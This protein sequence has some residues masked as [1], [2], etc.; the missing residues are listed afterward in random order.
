MSYRSIISLMP[1]TSVDA[2]A[3]AFLTAAAITDPTISSSIDKLVV[4]MKS[5]GV[6]T[7][8]KAIYPMVGGTASTHKFNLKD[9][10]D[11]DAAFRLSF[12]GGWTHSANGALPNGTNGYAN[13]FLTASSQ[14][15]INSA[16]LSFY[17]RTQLATGAISIGSTYGGL[18][19]NQANLSLSDGVNGFFRINSTATSGI[20]NTSSLGLHI[21]NRISSSETRNSI[22]GVL[23]TQ[24]STS[25]SLNTNNILLAASILDGHTLTGYDSKQCAFSSIGMGL[26]DTEAANFY[27]AVQTF[28]TSLGRSIGTQT[29]SDADAQAFV[30]NAA[31]VDQVEANAVNKLVIDMKAA[32]VWSKMKAIYPFVGG[33]ASSHKFNLKDPRDLD[34]AF[35]LQFFGGVT[36]SSNGVQGNGT[37]GYANTFLSPA[38]NL[39]QNSTHLSFY[40]RTNVSSTQAELGS[41]GINTIERIAMAL[42]FSGNFSSDLYNQTT[43]RV[44]AANANSTG[45]YV[46]SRINSTTH[47]AFKNNSQL[48]ST[49]TGASGNISLILNSIE[50]L[51]FNS[52]FY[53]TKQCAFSSIGDGLT[54]TEVTNLYNAIQ[55]FQ[56]TLNR[57]V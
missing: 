54:D 38:S 15:S 35:R 5:A 19:G 17:S 57:Q 13:T 40:S 7:K 20:S 11:L 43:G 48:G 52:A 39:I 29:V 1:K 23:R 36:H 53:S 12:L 8:M 9:P 10:R 14:L 6:W 49:N 3:Q 24:T 47:K 56:T 31:I 25:T 21:A 30:T 45:F 37:N 32:G 51:R 16:H 4:D 22:R 34:A 46:G 28:Q 42:S 55:T 27:T 41:L 26:T 18:I 2:D 33:S 50:V 44:A